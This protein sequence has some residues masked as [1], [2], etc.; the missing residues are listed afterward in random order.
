MNLNL[1]VGRIYDISKTRNVLMQ[2]LNQGCQPI[3]MRARWSRL[4]ASGLRLGNVKKCSLSLPKDSGSSWSLFGRSGMLGGFAF[5]SLR[6]TKL[7]P[8]SRGVTL[9][10]LKWNQYIGHW[11]SM[12]VPSFCGRTTLRTMIFMTRLQKGRHILAANQPAVFSM[13]WNMWAQMST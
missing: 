1:V 3:Q 6:R 13:V 11:W 9:A 5:W 7:C 2:S 8:F 10:H 12:I 4:S